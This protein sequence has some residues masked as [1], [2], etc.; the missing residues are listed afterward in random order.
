M[1]DLIDTVQLQEIS[2][3]LIQLFEVTLPSGTV[4]YLH[5]GLEEGVTS[6]F[7]PNKEGT[8]INEYVTIP[9]EVVGV[10]TSSTG[11]IPRPTLSMANIPSLTRNQS[12]NEQLGPDLL[13]DEGLNSNEDLIGMRVD[14]RITLGK[15]LSASAGE[16]PTPA[17]EFPSQTYVIDRVS[18]ESNIAVEFEL[19][20][21]MDVE[22]V[23]L[24][25]R[26]VIGRYCPWKYQGYYLDGDGGCVWDLDS[27][28]RFFTQSNSAIDTSG[29]NAW[30]S[31]N[32]TYVSGTRVK[33]VE[34]G[35]YAG[36]YTR[37]WEA[38]RDVPLNRNPVTSKSYWKRIDVCGKLIESCKVRF[39]ET[40]SGD[41]DTNARLPFGGFPG[42][43]KIK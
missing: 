16:A 20:S 40:I 38:L 41:T 19:A 26:N 12:S 39:Q 22:G 23:K 36:E 17:V 8:A 11:R 9:I 35:T 43:R 28:N 18:A 34:T 2:D 6:V 4:A 33:T 25:A 30:S 5:K 32:A 21:P 31:D 27:R 15:Y 29:I 3:S 24:P 1:T 13:V 37:I 42:T 14:Y 7:F 10:K